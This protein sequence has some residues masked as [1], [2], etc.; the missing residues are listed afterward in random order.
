MSLDKPRIPK[1]GN[2]FR[3]FIPKKQRKTMTD[4]F[5]DRIKR[6]RTDKVE[7]VSGRMVETRS[8]KSS[9]ER[10]AMLEVE[11][12]TDQA[13]NE[14]Q[15]VH[16]P[17]GRG[18]RLASESTP[19][20]QGHDFATSTGTLDREEIS[21]LSDISTEI[22]ATRRSPT[23]NTMIAGGTEKQTTSS[24]FSER[25]RNTLGNIFPFTMGVGTGNEGESQ[26]EEEDE[27][28]QV[29][30]GSQVSLNRLTQENEA[31][32][33][34]ETGTMDKFGVVRTI[35]KDANTPGQSRGFALMTNSEARTGESR[36]K[37]LGNAL[38]DPEVDNEKTSIQRVKARI[39][40][41][42]KLPGTDRVTPP[43]VTPLV[44][45]G[46]A[47][48]EALNNIVGSMGEQNEQ[49]SLRMSELERAV[50]IERESL[51]EEINRNRQEVGRSE[52][53]LKERTDEHIAKN[54]SRMTR[55][56]EQRELRLREDM[57]KMRNQ[58]EQS[59]G[60][61]D[62]KIDAMME[63]RTQVIMDMLD[64]LLG[65]KSGPKER[66]PNSGG[67]SR[68][69]KVNFN[70]HHRRRTYG[71]TRGRGSSS[72]YATRDNRTWGPNSRASSTGNRQ[73]SNER[74]TQG[75]HATGRG[76]SGNR[77]HASPGRSHV[78]QGGNTHGD[79]DCRDA[80]NTEPL[81]RCDDTQAGHSRDA[82]A[83][84]TA[85]EPLNRSLE[86]LLTR[87]SK[88]NE[89]S[90]KSR[91]VFKKPRCFKDES[92]G[93]IDT[94]I[95]VMKLRFEEEDLSERQE[96][97]ALTS[98]LRG[99]ALNCVMAKKQYQ[100]DTA[101][102]IFEILLN[103]FRSG[104]QGHQAMMRFEKRRQR[105]DETIDKFL[106][107]LEMLRRR[108]QPDEPNRRMKLAVASKFIDGVK[109]DELRT[110][111]ATH[112][113]PLSTNAPTPEGLR[114]KSKEYLLL[115]PP[116]RSGCYKNNNGNFNNGP[117]NQGN[118]W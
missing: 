66:E 89:R 34:R 53:R 1:R 90:E 74:P 45:N 108:S 64:G 112:Y 50:H 9:E 102:K 81:T 86:T 99:T 38:A 21:E 32:V 26:E 54:L 24:S 70:D 73:T 30:F 10:K 117:A 97:S 27:G 111:L 63:T 110:I 109:N 75:T 17:E 88:T 103:R 29:D 49:M 51:R 43:L 113:T 72:G 83:I 19:V 100:R 40:T 106:D 96:C 93:C 80:P 25:M 77:R 71:S 62:T 79:S 35:S 115:K 67:P 76:D 58:Q 8:Q 13:M 61:L 42:T 82:T 47:L 33:E 94:W 39:S 6:A 68:E 107:D 104:V 18:R 95:E 91:R 98:N 12:H 59:L 92:D 44:D 55:E 20:E 15:E 16:G 48:E 22:V 4:P 46:A 116:S 3:K 23:E 78:G 101:E 11:I 7:T 118:N 105:E 69:L 41:S 14:N 87:L 114:L 52:K 56:A 85:F 28:E 31:N 37:G 5:V 36:N 84:A 65:S 2:S 57:E 60:T